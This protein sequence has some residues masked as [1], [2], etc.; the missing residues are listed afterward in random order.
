MDE[1]HIMYVCV[2]VCTC[3][4]VCARVRMSERETESMYACTHILKSDDVGMLAVPE[5]NL[6]LLRGIG[7][8]LV[9]HLSIT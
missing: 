7:V 2:C 5:Q 8:G 4:G 1:F 9:N 6:Y 3:L